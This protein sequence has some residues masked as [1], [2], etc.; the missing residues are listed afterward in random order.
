MNDAKFIKQGLY[1]QGLSVYEADISYIQNILF[2][3]EQAQ[4]S[5]NAF[6]DLN[7][8]VPITV[9]DKRLMLWQN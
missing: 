3:I 5:L 2:T 9:T 7:Q 4:K 1:L 6:P 8:E